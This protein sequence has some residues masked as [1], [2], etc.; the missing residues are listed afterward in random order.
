MNRHIYG[1]T[2]FLAVVKIHFLL[3][4]AFFAPINFFS[5]QHIS[6]KPE[7]VVIEKKKC[8][9]KPKSVLEL[10]NIAA[11]FKNGAVSANIKINDQA[12]D[13]DER[14]FRVQFF[15]ENKK[16]VWAS[17]VEIIKLNKTKTT[18]TLPF[19]SQEL[20]RLNIKSNYYARIY[21]PGSTPFDYFRIQTLEGL[22]PVLQNKENIGAGCGYG[23]GYG[24]SVN[25]F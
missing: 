9:L 21:E 2:L 17:Q 7:N 11:N 13:S 1:L 6:V 25:D 18:L 12:A 24:H 3:Y 19:C 20:A 22:T 4:W 10:Q 5:T 23:R 15:D 14:Q 16:F 8:N